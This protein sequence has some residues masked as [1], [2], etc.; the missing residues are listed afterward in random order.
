MLSSNII[1][2]FIS[3]YEELN[4][5]ENYGTLKDYSNNRME[6]VQN[7]NNNIYMEESI[8]NDNDPLVNNFITTLLNPY[9]KAEVTK[10]YNND[11]YYCLKD[12][13]VLEVFKAKQDNEC[14]FN[15]KIYVG[16]KVGTMQPAYNN[17]IIEF[18]VTPNAV[19]TLSVKNPR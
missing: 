6:N 13:E 3:A 9:I 16:V 11:M 2:R 5:I 7:N 19:S 12:V 1:V 18:L 14:E 17:L 10:L 8:L 15:Y 4:K